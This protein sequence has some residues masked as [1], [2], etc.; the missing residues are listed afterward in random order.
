M[1]KKDLL[2]REHRIKNFERHFIA[3]I[4]LLAAITLI[5]LAYKGPLYKADIVY[6]THPTV[7]N[8]L[9]AQDAVNAFFM[10]PILIIAAFGL[11]LKWKPARYFLA[12]TPL[13]MIYYAISYGLGWEWMAPEYS[14]NSE[15]W[16]FHF[17]Y[18]LVSSLLILMYSFR[19]FPN[20]LKCTFQRKA[21]VI[22]S[23]LCG[24]F[25]AMFAL[26]WSRE[27]FEVLYTGSTRSYDLAPTAFWLVRF[28]DLGF[29]IPLGFVSIY[30]L[31]VSPARSFALQMLFFGFFISMSVVVNAMALVMYLNNDPS[32]EWGSSLVFLALLC[33]V[34]FGYI[35]ILKG[36]L[37]KRG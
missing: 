36:Y 3:W 12:L 11:W 13:F 34:I 4:A 27:V 31:W 14:G 20:K 6:R 2:A 30:L 17:L 5:Y 24:L 22:Y 18:I 1:K 26:M 15:A 25:L 9:I 19:V 28:F 7:Y 37:S 35:F 10:A 21:L 29:S 23:V 8:Q 32:F 33:I 16:F